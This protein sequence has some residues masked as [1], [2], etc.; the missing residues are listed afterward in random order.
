VIQ[1]CRNKSS[2]TANQ[3]LEP[4]AA[5]PSVCGCAGR[6]AACGFDGCSVPGRCGSAFGWTVWEEVPTLKG[7]HASGGALMQPL[8][9]C[10]T[11]CG[12]FTQGRPVDGPTLSWRIEPRWGSRR[13]QWSVIPAEDEYGDA[14]DC[15]P[16]GLRRLPEGAVVSGPGRRRIWGRRGL[17][18]YRVEGAAKRGIFFVGT[19][20]WLRMADICEQANFLI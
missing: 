20:V 1:T 6:F 5:A 10:K 18:P 11:C 15:I 3:T 13:G 19:W 2:A 16:T 8:Q 9:G 12:T 4:P 14:G 7:L 17:H